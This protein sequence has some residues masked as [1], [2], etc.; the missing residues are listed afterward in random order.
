MKKLIIFLLT[1]ASLVA[2]TVRN[3]TYSTS[4]RILLPTNLLFFN[5]VF[6]NNWYKGGNFTNITLDSAPVF[7]YA[8]ANRAAYF[9]ASKELQSSTTTATQLG[10]IDIATGTEG[11]GE[12]VF[13]TQPRFEGPV[14]IN[15]PISADRQFMVYSTDPTDNR[16]VARFYAEPELL[17][18]VA[19]WYGVYNAAHIGLSG[20]NITDSATTVNSSILI[21][22][23]GGVNYLIQYLARPELDAASPA[24]ITNTHPFRVS[25]VNSSLVGGMHYHPVGLYMLY[26]GDGTNSLNT[27][28]LLTDITTPTLEGSRGLDLRMSS[29]TDK[30]NIYQS[31]SASNYIAGPTGF[32]E[33]VRVNGAQLQLD[34]GSGSAPALAWG[35]APTIG[36]YFTGG[37]MYFTGDLYA[38]NDISLNG[39]L[40]LRNA[41][42][43]LEGRLSASTDGEIYV[44]NAAS[45]AAASLR[46][47][48]YSVS[49]STSISAAALESG[50][51]YTTGGT[52]QVIITLPSGALG[53]WAT[54]NVGNTG[55]FLVA[56]TNSATIN[57]AGTT[58]A[59]NGY[60]SSST[61]G[62]SV[63]LY[64][65][66]TRWV[67]L[68]NSGDWTVDGVATVTGTGVNVRANSPTLVTPTLTNPITTESAALGSDDTYTGN[69]IVGLNNTGG[70]TQW[71][72]VYL[73]GSSQWVLAD[74]NG[75]GT[76]PAR[77]IAT[78]TVATGNATTVIVR[79]T[80]RNDSWNWTPGG[81]IYLS[82]TPGGLTQT[83]PAT[84]GD[85]VQQVG[86][87][88][89]ADIAYFDLN[90]TY[91]TV[92]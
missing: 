3:P 16:E 52:N 47:R 58:T 59:A 50:A 60:L 8:T 68:G 35:S 20:F 85:Q 90:S 12:I 28:I 54:F 56:A 6:S 71:D 18:D 42:G 38:T 17:A 88:L 31:G 4:D 87:A 48:R 44:R 36:M 70:V 65:D 23:S 43:T 79:G 82:A 40:L 84:S 10:Y 63:T 69:T 89:T 64:F 26:S 86:F 81:T 77:G 41:S 7:S 46:F 33:K 74:A 34:T 55:G 19:R 15:T 80:I 51:V 2:Q 75:S 92:P 45:T 5:Q 13:D 53:Q 73:N 29:G 27:H 11:T 76:Y 83:A 66:S 1:T 62:D 24:V 14:T 57:F 9:G 72:T 21:E 49:T 30:F 32:Y 22:E 61:S 39:E 67:V 78:A 25:I 37:G 91:V